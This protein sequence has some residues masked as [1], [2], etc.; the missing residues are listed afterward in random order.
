MKILAI[1]NSFSQD[2]TAYLH[3]MAEAGGMET[4][5]VNLFIPAV[6]WKPIG[7]TPAATVQPIAMS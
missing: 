3:R 7:K 5:I 2:A 4:K 6:P 1:G